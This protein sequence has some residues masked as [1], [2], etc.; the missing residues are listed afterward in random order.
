MYNTSHGARGIPNKS[1]YEQK[2][3]NFR[4]SS[5]KAATDMGVSSSESHELTWFY[6]MLMAGSGVLLEIW[7]KKA[8]WLQDS[9]LVR[10]STSGRSKPACIGDLHM[11]LIS[12]LQWVGAGGAGVGLL[13]KK[14][15]NRK[16]LK[17]CLFWQGLPWKNRL[18]EGWWKWHQARR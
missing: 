13:W 15:E 4:F 10:H 1:D 11:G 6:K 17:A 12:R 16:R 9:R 18:R 7:S 2:Y 3:N 5:P 8:P 14:S